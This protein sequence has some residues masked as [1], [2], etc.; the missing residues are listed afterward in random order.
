MNKS[1]G[2]FQKIVAKIEHIWLVYRKST[3]ETD[4]FLSYEFR[5]NRCL[6]SVQSQLGSEGLLKRPLEVIAPQSKDV[7][8]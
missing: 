8:N 7:W 3:G 4:P 1:Q 6:P 2:A 5:M